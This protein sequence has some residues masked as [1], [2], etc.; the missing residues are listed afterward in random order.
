M[1][2]SKVD[3]NNALTQ[4]NE[5]YAKMITDIKAL[6]DR[7]TQLEESKNPSKAAAVSAS[8]KEKAA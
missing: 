6:Q 2:V 8:V 4:I 1:V 3:F 5:S 7:V